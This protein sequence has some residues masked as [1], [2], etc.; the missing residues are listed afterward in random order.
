M[1]Y[2]TNR[3]DLHST[4]LSNSP[5]LLSHARFYGEKLG[6]LMLC[7]ATTHRQA[8]YMLAPEHREGIIQRD[9]E[10]EK[11]SKGSSDPEQAVELAGKDYIHDSASE[12]SVCWVVLLWWC[13]ADERKK[14]HGGGGTPYLGK[15]T[16][17]TT[18][19][20]CNNKSL[21]G[22]VESMVMLCPMP[23]WMA[24]INSDVDF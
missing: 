23:S 8:L 19:K 20:S 7:F 12:A 9:S 16:S 14:E 11:R 3:S 18:E 15:N 10:R 24:A 17:S 4:L 2:A 6:L 13:T 22:L 1:G 21:L 5:S